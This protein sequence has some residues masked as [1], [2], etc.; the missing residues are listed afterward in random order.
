MS[1][2]H[3]W[4]WPYIGNYDTRSTLSIRVEK[5]VEKLRWVVLYSTPSTSKLALANYF[6]ATY[7]PVNKQVMITSMYIFGDAKLWWQTRTNDDNA[8]GRPRIKTWEMLKK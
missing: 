3:G 6:S 2:W 5:T 7:I 1:K 8:A 4:K